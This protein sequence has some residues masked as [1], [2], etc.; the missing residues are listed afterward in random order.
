[1]YFRTPI[2]VWAVMLLLGVCHNPLSAQSG[3]LLRFAPELYQSSRFQPAYQADGRFIISLGNPSMSLT[4]SG[5]SYQD[6]FSR[7]ADNEFKLDLEPVLNDLRDEEVIFLENRNDLAG[8]A[9]SLGKLQIGAHVSTVMV[10][11]LTYS[12]ELVELLWYGSESAFDG[13]IRSFNLGYET[14][15]YAEAG[16][17]LSFPVT[18]KLRIGMR[19]SRLKGIFYNTVQADEFRVSVN[20]NTRQMSLATDM[21]YRRAGYRLEELADDPTA[22]VYDMPII[23]QDG[24][25]RENGGYSIDLGF[26]LQLGK[27]WTLDASAIRLGQINWNQG[28]VEAINQISD[29]LAGIQFVELS[30]NLQG[31]DL[32]VLIGDLGEAFNFEQAIPQP[33]FKQNLNPEFYTGLR[34]DA[35]K[36]L[37]LG[38]MLGIHDQQQRY[39]VSSHANATIHIGRNVSLGMNYSFL[40]YRDNM[41]GTMLGIRTGMLQLVAT[42]SLSSPFS[43][44]DART[45]HAQIGINLIF[46]HTRKRNE[47]KDLIEVPEASTEESE[48]PQTNPD[49][50]IP[51]PEGEGE[52]QSIPLPEIKKEKG[53]GR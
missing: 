26:T 21:I 10:G 34:Y 38:G 44:T 27:R 23:S 48:E 29:T 8:V 41:V 3:A 35:G 14:Y 51:L 9:I 28:Y 49:A 19:A 20:P 31:E 22:P 33:S 42:Q 40:P 36:V 24:N 25:W 7:N 50:D 52:E 15:G 5:F 53:D 1:M 6:I 45:L 12:S 16:V 43:P 11:D 4:S 46:G 47:P 30:Q 2:A 13:R 37:S 17:T 32:G 39:L 18:K